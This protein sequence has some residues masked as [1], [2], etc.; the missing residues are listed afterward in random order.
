MEQQQQQTGYFKPGESVTVEAG[1]NGFIV[2]T[3]KGVFIADS[4][5]Q[6]LALVLGATTNHAEIVQ[7]QQITSAL[8]KAQQ[9]AETA[10]AANDPLYGDEITSDPGAA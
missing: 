1:V 4:V 3:E 6:M 2:H 7:R 10:P 8:Q 9:E 5:Q